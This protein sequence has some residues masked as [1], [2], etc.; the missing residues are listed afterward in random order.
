MNYIAWAITG[1]VGYSLVTMFVKLATRSGQ[2]SSF[3]VLAIATSIVCTST[4]SI[5]ALRGDTRG[6]VARDF[7]S[8]SALWA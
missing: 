3:V 7:G 6:L 1:M 4:L 8:S 5:R 2:F